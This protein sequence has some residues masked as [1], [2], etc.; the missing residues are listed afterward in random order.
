M[1]KSRGLTIQELAE[2]AQRGLDSLES[3]PPPRYVNRDRGFSC[4][5]R[6]MTPGVAE[7]VSVEEQYRAIG[8]HLAGDWG[9]V[10]PEDWEANEEALRTGARLFSVYRT[11]GG[12][13]FWVITEADRSSTCLLLP[14][15][16]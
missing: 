9:E 16:Y 3:D 10:G 2:R 8:R 4:G 5:L 11:A 15:E 14:E 6:S 13:T 1:V 12:T 7:R